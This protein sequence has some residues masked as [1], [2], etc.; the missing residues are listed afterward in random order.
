MAPIGVK[1]GALSDLVQPRIRDG[2]LHDVDVRQV[3]QTCEVGV[4]PRNGQNCTLRVGL[5]FADG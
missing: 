1:L 4:T 3:A 2:R 5:A